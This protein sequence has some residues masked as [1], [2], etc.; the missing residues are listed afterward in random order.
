MWYYDPF[1][2]VPAVL[3]GTGL[4][5]CI[6]GII[7][8]RKKHKILSTICFVFAAPCVLF[9]TF[10]GVLGWVLNNEEVVRSWIGII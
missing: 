10:I 2:T 9:S 1:L 5:F 8:L 3:T 4:I 7:M 6:L